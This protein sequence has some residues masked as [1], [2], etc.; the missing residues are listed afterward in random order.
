MHRLGT[1]LTILDVPDQRWNNAFEQ[2]LGAHSIISS[3]MVLAPAG[4]DS[5]PLPLAD[6]VNVIC[7]DTPPR[8]PAGWIVAERRWMSC[9]CC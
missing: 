9:A 8:E 2:R 6:A 3:V 1:P 4:S 7:R 5:V